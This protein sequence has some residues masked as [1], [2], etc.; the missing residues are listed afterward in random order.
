MVKLAVREAPLACDD[1]LAFG[2]GV[3]DALEQVGDVEGKYVSSLP[4]TP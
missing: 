1:R 4:C 2:D 3:G